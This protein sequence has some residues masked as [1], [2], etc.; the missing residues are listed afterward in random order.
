MVLPLLKLK[1]TIEES[2]RPDLLYSRNSR[3]SA[4]GLKHIGLP[5]VM[6][7]QAC[8]WYPSHRDN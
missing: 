5:S 6:E 3:R 7:G 4:H 2:M 1:S 8:K